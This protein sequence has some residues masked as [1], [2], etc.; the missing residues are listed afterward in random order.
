MVRRANRPVEEKC[1]SL[2]TSGWFGLVECSDAYAPSSDVL[3]VQ[4]ALCAREAVALGNCSVDVV[5]SYDVL[6]AGDANGSGGD[7]LR[8]LFQDFTVLRVHRHGLIGRRRARSTS[9]RLLSSCRSAF[10]TC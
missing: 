2:T 6:R 3:N 1:I 8:D 7:H 5:L 10:R 4:F 9:M